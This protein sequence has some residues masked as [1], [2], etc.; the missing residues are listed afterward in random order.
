MAYQERVHILN[1]AEQQDFYGIPHFTSNDQ[2]YFFA[3]NDEERAVAQKIRDRSQRCMFV[4]LLGYFKAKP[5]ALKT[6]YHLIKEDLRYI[7]ESILPGPGHRPFNLAQKEA[8]R[9]YHRIYLLC[10]FY[11]WDAGIH[12]DDL[13]GHLREHAN[14]WSDSRYL[15]DM[16]IEYLAANRVAIPGYS[17]LQKLIGQIIVSHYDHLRHQL[18]L[19]LPA[20]ATKAILSIVDD[21]AGALSLRELRQSA[22]NFSKAE[23]TKELAVHQYM[24]EWISDVESA[25]KQISLSPKNQQ[26][27]AARIDHYGAKLKRQ[28]SSNQLLYLLCYLQ[29]R[30]ERALERIADGLV[31]HIRKTHEAA[32]RFAQESVYNAWRK[33]QKNVS[34]AADVLG[35]F[36]DESI[37][38]Q[39][40]FGGIRDDVFDLI[41]RHDLESL[42]L[43]LKDQRRSVGDAAWQFYETQDSL[44]HELIRPLFLCLRFEGQHGSEPLARLLHQV[45]NEFIEKGALS[46][47]QVYRH[48]LSAKQR[49]FLEDTEG[50]IYLEGH[51]DNNRPKPHDLKVGRR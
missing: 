2:R 51:R 6:R 46:Q 3:L 23:L 35:Y 1:E 5:V 24:R 32:R 15:F 16:A 20:N 37:K 28:S 38:P 31:H 29:Q 4:L 10:G 8:A 21:D 11:R 7:S 13:R 18:D 40:P 9:L 27:Y 14:L 17:T 49:P 43:F 12:E 47:S 36:L 45:Q 26:H 30:W 44:R 41:N 48:N 50:N 25:L 22:R 34:K 39:Q 42:C 19:S 33:A